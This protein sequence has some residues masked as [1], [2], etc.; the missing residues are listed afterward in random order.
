[1]VGVLDGLSQVAIEQGRD[2]R[3]LKES[4]CRSVHDPGS[5]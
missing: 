4:G 2:C 1:M 3:S 5:V